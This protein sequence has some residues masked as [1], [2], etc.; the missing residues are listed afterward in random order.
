M[1]DDKTVIVTGGSSGIGAEV[2]RLFANSGANVVAVSIKNEEKQISKNIAHIE[3]DIRN[4]GGVKKAVDEV[5]KK[6]GRIDIVVNVGGVPSQEDIK[7]LSLKEYQNIIDINLTGMFLLT[8]HTLPHLL[9]S[10]GTVINVASQLGL[11]PDPNFPVCCASKAAVVMFTKAMAVRY[12]SD[13]VRINCVCHGP[14]SIPS[15]GKG[16]FVSKLL[17]GRFGTPEEVANVVFFLASNKSSYV[18]GAVYT[19]DGGSSLARPHRK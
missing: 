12:A 14:T 10:K 2:A 6:F 7:S 8:K 11:V 16:Y 1:F 3:T 15:I 5:L 4:E 9:I 18:T 17:E 13:G 19:V